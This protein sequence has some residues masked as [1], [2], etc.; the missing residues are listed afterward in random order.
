ML[1]SGAGKVFDPSGVLTDADVRKRLQ[2]FIAGF[3][4]FI[5]AHGK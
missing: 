5:A 3:A 1:V 4:A 2:D